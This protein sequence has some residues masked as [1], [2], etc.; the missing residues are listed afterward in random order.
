MSQ[1]GIEL[2]LLNMIT[3]K[4]LCSQVATFLH[5]PYILIDDTLNII[6]LLGDMLIGPVSRNCIL[7]VAF[8]LGVNSKFQL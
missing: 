4:V 8:L 7:L 1:F 5:L 2:I 3:C 6:L